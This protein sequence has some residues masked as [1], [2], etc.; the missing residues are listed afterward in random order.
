VVDLIDDHSRYLLAA[1]AGSAATGERPGTPSK[2]LFRRQ[3]HRYPGVEYH[4]RC[5]RHRGR[6]RVNLDLGSLGRCPQGLTLHR[7]RCRLEAAP[8]HIRHQC[9]PRLNRFTATGQY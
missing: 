2:Q 4:T 3:N 5:L 6:S 7:N 1:I 8:R 9:R